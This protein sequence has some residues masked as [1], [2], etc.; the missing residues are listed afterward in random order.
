MRPVL[1]PDEASALDAAARSRGIPAATLMERAGHATARAAMHLAG[2][3]YGRRVIVAC[4]A[5][6]NGGDG[7]VAARLLRARGLAV[8][9]HAVGDAPSREPVASARAAAEAAGVE[10]VPFAPASFARDLAR[11]DAAVDALVGVGFRGPA[12]DGLATAIRAFGDAGCPVLAVDVPS[13]LDAATGAVSD[14][15]VRADA[16]V[17][18]GATKVGL[19]LAPEV[20]GPVEVVDLGIP[21]DLVR[22]SVGLV[23]VEDV[24][25]LLPRRPPDAHKRS[26]GIVL[27]VAGSLRMPGAGT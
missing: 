12:R 24:A 1:T 7:Y 10:V 5:G 22:A 27:V 14:A 8:S 25:A 17:T 23:D 21:P 26:T 2:G 18:F 3:R 13:G 6:N 11:A 20:C 4:G 19:V 15:V 16:T 9:V